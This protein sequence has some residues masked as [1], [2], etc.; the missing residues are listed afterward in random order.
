MTVY[1]AKDAHDF[2]TKLEQAAAVPDALK[3][4]SRNTARR[5]T[6]AD[7]YRQIEPLLSMSRQRLSQALER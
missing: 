5:Q 7:R 3:A 4:L 6:W 2:V 1:I